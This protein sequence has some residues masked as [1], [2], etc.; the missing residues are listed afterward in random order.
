M[1]NLSDV[2]SGD[3]M[4]HNSFLNK[5]LNKIQTSEQAMSLW[6]RKQECINANSPCSSC[7]I[8]DKCFAASNRCYADIMKAYGTEN[9]DFPD[10]RCYW[11][12]KFINNVTHE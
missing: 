12:P 4:M 6:K 10:P 7:K 3:V 9:F 2:P 8:F 5:R 1:K 11:A